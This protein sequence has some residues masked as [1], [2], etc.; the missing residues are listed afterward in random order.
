M[1]S[2]AGLP[3]LP[4]SSQSCTGASNNDFLWLFFQ[5]TKTGVEQKATTFRFVCGMCWSRDFLKASKS[6]WEFFKKNW[7]KF[8]V[9][10]YSSNMRHG[11]MR[12]KFR[13][14]RSNMKSFTIWFWLSLS[15][16]SGTHSGEMLSFARTKHA[17]NIKKSLKLMN[18]LLVHTVE[19]HQWMHHLRNAHV[20]AGTWL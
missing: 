13:E 4:L 9:F 1:P 7:R 16:Y 17:K 15:N 12:C 3:P 8:G 19:Y 11:E 5:Q 2:G 6:F 10:H 18:W 14:K 20:L